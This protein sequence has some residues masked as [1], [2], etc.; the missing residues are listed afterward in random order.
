[1]ILAQPLNF[2]KKTFEA[3]LCCWIGS[4]SE[5]LN[6]KMKGIFFPLFSPKNIANISATNIP[7]H[8]FLCLS[9]GNFNDFKEKKDVL[10]FAIENI[11]NI[12]SDPEYNPKQV[13]F[14]LFYNQTIRNET[15]HAAN[16]LLEINKAIQLSCKKKQEEAL[17]FCKKKGI[18]NPTDKDLLD[19]IPYKQALYNESVMQIGYEKQYK[20]KMLVQEDLVKQISRVKAVDDDI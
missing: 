4:S 8:N 7:L 11:A 17:F 3:P 14:G 15:V 1:M 16:T 12:K 20:L 19:Y 9:Y 2:N 5:D 13:T 10:E 18:N 6:E